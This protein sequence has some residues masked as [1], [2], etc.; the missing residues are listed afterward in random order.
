MAFNP[1]LMV[2]SFHF[3]A[4]FV[5]LQIYYFPEFLLPPLLRYSRRFAKET[6][7]RAYFGKKLALKAILN[8]IGFLKPGVSNSFSAVSYTYMPGFYTGQTL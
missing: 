5:K 7:L 2:L 6:V 1:F 8:V 4:V 3:C